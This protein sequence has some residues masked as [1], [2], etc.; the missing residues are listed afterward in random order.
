MCGEA[1][2]NDRR[3]VTVL[4]PSINSYRL[5][6]LYRVRVLLLF[7]VFFT[8]LSVVL[9]SSLLEG[10]AGRNHSVQ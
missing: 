2:P 1:T 7:F 6:V 5:A 3:A 8:G 4:C 10:L 9:S